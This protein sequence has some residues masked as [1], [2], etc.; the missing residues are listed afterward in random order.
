MSTQSIFVCPDPVL[1]LRL[2]LEPKP[3]H[4]LR[5]VSTQA[6]EWSTTGRGAALALQCAGMEPTAVC[7]HLI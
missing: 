1:L 6:Q 2:L 4:S 5:Y 7:F 3:H